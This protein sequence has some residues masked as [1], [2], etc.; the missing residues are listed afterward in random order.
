[1][2]IVL[3]GCDGTG[4]SSIAKLIQAV[5]PGAEIVH[6]TAETPNDFKFFSK[7]I[8]IGQYRNI[9]LDRGMYGQFVYQS[10]EDRKLS[11]KQLRALE[12]NMIKTGAKVVHVTAMQQTIED[13]L[14][15]RSEVP[16]HTVS[17][18]L[19]RFDDLF[20]KS[21]MPV[22]T[23]DTTNGLEIGGKF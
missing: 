23:V 8:D 13:R 6:C 20:E 1:M 11:H 9:I 21:L 2:L 4:K 12:L 15:S 17:V 18:L 10:P 7:L 5:M 16:M 14:N 3:E 19:S 22:I